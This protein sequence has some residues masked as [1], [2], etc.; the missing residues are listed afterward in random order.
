MALRAGPRLLF[1]FAVIP[2]SSIE[3][4][5]VYMGANGCISRSMIRAETIQVTPEILALIAEID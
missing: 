3:S 2:V 4:L 1:R 5:W